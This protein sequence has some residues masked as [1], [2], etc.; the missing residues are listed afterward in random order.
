MAAGRGTRMYPLTEN[1]PKA[2]APFQNETLI[3]NSIKKIK[4]HVSHIHVTVGYKS[5]M[6]A[7]HLM[8]IGV[9]SIF[10]T[11]GHSNSWWVYNTFLKYLDEPVFVLTCDNI[12]DLDFERL[13]LDYKTS[14]EP[15]CM[16]VPVNPVE[17]LEGDFIE[18]KNRKVL[19][20]QRDI[21]KDIYCS[22]I[23]VLNPLKIVKLTK[24]KKSFYDIWKQLIKL[25]QLY[26]SSIYPKKWFTVD[27][28]EQLARV[29]NHYNT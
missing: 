10:N 8:K 12:I 29:E 26:I 4:K 6:L 21:P 11:E 3:A 28:I 18:H 22:G 16:L 9:N 25:E 27:T 5:T 15:A 7:E 19:S 17:G 20:V 24:E 1:I 23:Q 13:A 2:M 14:N